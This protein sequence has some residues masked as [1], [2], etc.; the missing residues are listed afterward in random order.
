ME[1]WWEQTSVLRHVKFT[2]EKL[3]Q[4][5]PF[6][7][8]SRSAPLVLLVKH[9]RLEQESWEVKQL[10]RSW[11]VLFCVLCGTE[12]KWI[13]SEARRSYTAFKKKTLKFLAHKTLRFYQQTTRLKLCKITHIPNTYTICGEF[14][15]L[16]LSSGVCCC[17]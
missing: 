4:N 5:S 2:W 9:W 3:I 14:K 10:K 17:Y 8:F 15:H 7:Y 11:K 6:W 1:G 16:W 12:M 13:T